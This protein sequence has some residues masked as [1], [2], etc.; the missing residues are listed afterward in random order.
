VE[1]RNS[2]GEA[3]A[4]PLVSCLVYSALVVLIVGLV[5]FVVWLNVRG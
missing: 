4:P 5:L 2:E 3:D 1:E